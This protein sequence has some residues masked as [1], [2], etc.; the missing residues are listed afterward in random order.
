MEDWQQRTQLLLGDEKMELLRTGR[1]VEEKP[2]MLQ[3][4]FSVMPS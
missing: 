2:E 4:A 1:A 3:S